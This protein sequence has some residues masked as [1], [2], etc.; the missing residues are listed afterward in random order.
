MS[1][2]TFGSMALM[3]SCALL[4]SCGI[5]GKATSSVDPIGE[6]WSRTMKLYHVL[7]VYPPTDDIHI[8]DVYA[9][10]S[11]SPPSGNEPNAARAKAEWNDACLISGAVK[12][13]FIPS[14]IDDLNDYYS[15]QIVFGQE[16]ISQAK[17]STSSAP[18][19][20]ATVPAKSASKG[21]ARHPA[22]DPHGNPA[23]GAS[24]SLSKDD[25]QGVISQV[26]AA[27]QGSIYVATGV[28]TS[29]PIAAFPAFSEYAAYDLS[30]SASLPV[31]VFDG[32]LGGGKSKSV[33]VSV[34]FDDVTTFGV[35]TIPAATKLINYCLEHIGSGWRCETGFIQKLLYMQTTYATDKR[36]VI[37][38]VNRIYMA[39]QITFSF[40]T[41]AKAGFSADLQAKLTKALEAKPVDSSTENT[42]SKP[43]SPT[44]GPA[45]SANAPMTESAM[46]VAQG[47]A[48]AQQAAQQA[49]QE[50]PAP[51][52][53]NKPQFKVSAGSADGRVIRLV[54]TFPRPIVIGYEAI[55]MP[56]WPDTAPS[57]APK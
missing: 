48:N 33:A 6:Q 47:A 4:M 41:D 14:M 7:P 30:A 44:T 45:K 38:M 23:K 22:Q 27:P 56:S 35:P 50:V 43:P 11:C 51:S 49:D 24:S 15:K 5:K 3:T 8:G 26:A 54:E 29:L 16:N 17:G 20:P 39:K 53:S 12:I 46:T 13:D 37:G 18:N 2:R 19:A 21:V 31:G 34:Q 36:P 9:F 42:E 28:P 52:D 32:L 55:F 1:L 10:R 40:G 57:V 25:Q